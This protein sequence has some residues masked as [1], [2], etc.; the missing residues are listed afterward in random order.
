MS[1]EYSKINEEF[2]KEIQHLKE[3]LFEKKK[4][5][6]YYEEYISKLNKEN[7]EIKEELK[8]LKEKLKERM[9]KDSKLNEY[10]EEK[11]NNGTKIRK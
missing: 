9:L 8:A 3:N 6:N 11:K 5:I 7:Q 2:T 4:H 10:L 1:K